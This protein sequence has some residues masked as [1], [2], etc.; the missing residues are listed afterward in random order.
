MRALVLA[1]GA[2]TRMKSALPKALHEVNGR[3]ML[4]HALRA[5]RAA[6]VREIY[7]VVGHRRELVEERFAGEDV[8]WIVQRE[9][10]GTGHAVV[11]ARRELAGYR[12]ALLVVMGDACLLPGKLLR[13]LVKH[14]VASN[15]KCTVLSAFAA[16]PHGYGRIVRDDV[17]LVRRIVEERDATKAQKG[18]REINTGNYVFACP[19]VFAA[20]E[21]LRRDNQQGEY[22]LTDVVDYFAR[23]G[24]GVECLVAPSFEDVMAANTREELAT[25]ARVMNARTLSRL[26]AEGV[27]IVSPE[28]TF[29]HDTV[30]VGRDTIVQPFTVI[31][32]RVEIGKNCRIGPF[33]HIRDGS[34]L[35]DETAVGNFVEVKRSRMGPGTASRHIAYLGDARIGA[36]V[37]IGAG[38]ITANFDGERKQV[39]RIGDNARIGAGTI[40]IA[41]VRVGAGGRT[42]AGA[43]VPKKHHVGS[44]ETVVGIPA[45]RLTSKRG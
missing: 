34:H 43:V 44:G 35:S 14:Q 5:V 17:G 18:I 29:I 11:Q 21:A 31:T 36:K 26:M 9:Q 8:R 32:G 3:T 13:R 40:L 15:A 1:A 41:P 30:R 10:L 23:R 42:G 28:T 12:G 19:D 27:T 38:T 25:L 16:N 24:D 22:L 7:V 4:E 39:T 33:A 6:G 2:G 45:R 20:L 37:N